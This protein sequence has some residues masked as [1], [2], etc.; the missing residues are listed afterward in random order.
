MKDI[1]KIIEEVTGFTIKDLAENSNL[2]KEILYEALYQI[3]ERRG[4]CTCDNPNLQFARDNNKNGYMLCEDCL[5]EEN[6]RR[7]TQSK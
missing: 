3:K 4:Y 1:E 5:K 6:P 7:L 2:P